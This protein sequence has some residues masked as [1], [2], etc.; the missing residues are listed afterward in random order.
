MAVFQ[1]VSLFHQTVRSKLISRSEA[2]REILKNSQEKKSKF[3]VEVP[4]TLTIQPCRQVSLPGEKHE[5]DF[6]TYLFAADPSCHAFPLTLSLRT[7]KY[8]L[9]V[10]AVYC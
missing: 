3:S 4:E 1:Y 5:T 10:L 8:A 7:A 9:S 2:E 6:G